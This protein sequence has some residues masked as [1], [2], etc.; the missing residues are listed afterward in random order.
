MY[1]K[2]CIFPIILIHLFQ[3]AYIHLCCLSLRIL[4][5]VQE[6]FLTNCSY[7]TFMWFKSKVT[8]PFN[9][10]GSAVS[11]LFWARVSLSCQGLA[12]N[13]W[14]LALQV[15]TPY[16]WLRTKF[17]R[18]RSKPRYQP[19]E[20]ASCSKLWFLLVS[21]YCIVSTRADYNKFSTFKN[22]L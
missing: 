4:P 7:L 22:K 16:P 2:L 6:N 18:K 13:S 19:R 1:I 17:S 3:V 8:I 21:F 14:T 15:S 20:L 10:I 9:T 12:L 5:S 11:F